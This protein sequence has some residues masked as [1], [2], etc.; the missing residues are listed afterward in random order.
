MLIELG[1]SS[2]RLKKKKKK[3]FKMVDGGMGERENV[4]KNIAMSFGFERN[5]LIYFEPWANYK[6]Q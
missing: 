5:C 4:V 6:L 2:Y 3:S 1:F